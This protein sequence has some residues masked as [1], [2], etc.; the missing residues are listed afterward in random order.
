PVDNTQIY[1]VNE[2]NSLQPVGVLGEILI[3]GD[4]VA[5]G[6]LNKEAL[7]QEKFIINPFR[8]GERLYKTGDLGRWLPDGNIEFIGRKDDQ[9]KIRGHRIELGE[10]EHALVKHEAVNQAVV[11]ARE[12]ESAEKELVA[13][14][15]SNIEQNASDLRVYLK[16]SLPE[17]MLPAYFVQ[18]EAI[19]LTANGKIDKK[20]L[21]NPEGAGLSS[22]VAYVAPRNELE[23]R[24]VKICEEVLRREKIGVLDDFFGLGMNSL[25]VIRLVTLV[26]REMNIEL[27]INDIFEN[28]NIG[29]LS[30]KIESIMKV[31]QMNRGSNDIEFKHELEI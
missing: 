31:I 28:T 10:I 30:N 19:P 20:A 14:I 15:V 24:L 7:S 11:V 4:Q 27:R 8:A 17:Y 25:M 3:G 6:Y 16:Q 9:V 5:R 12:N 13:Y 21:P 2:K 29:N 22:G 18:L 1:I 26:H 23:E